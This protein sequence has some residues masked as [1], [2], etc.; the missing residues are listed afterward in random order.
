MQQSDDIQAPLE[1]TAGGNVGGGDGKHPRR[2]TFINKQCLEE[3]LKKSF[4]LSL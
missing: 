4:F 1:E 2:Y 3:E